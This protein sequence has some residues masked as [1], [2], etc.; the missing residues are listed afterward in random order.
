MSPS[1]RGLLYEVKRLALIAMW[2]DATA[3]TN[4]IAYFAVEQLTPK[5]PTDH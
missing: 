3:A 2:L 5:S 4:V 1:A